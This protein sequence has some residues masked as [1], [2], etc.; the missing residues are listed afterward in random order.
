MAQGKTVPEVVRKLGVTEQ[1]YY[2]WKRE[3]GGLRTD[4]AK[5]L[6]DLEKENA[7]LKRFGIWIGLDFEAG[8]F[9]KREVRR[10]RRGV[11]AFGQDH[12]PVRIHEIRHVSADD[13]L[14]AMPPPRRLAVQPV[15][16]QDLD[17]ATPVRAVGGDHNTQGAPACCRGPA[18]DFG[19]SGGDDTGNFRTDE[20]NSGMEQSRTRSNV[21]ATGFEPA[22]STS[23]T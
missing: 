5:R 7:R 13:A 14:P 8:K 12:L 10:L 22:T 2:R 18:V 20:P 9:G 4:Q 19:A 1:T 6:E 17:A 21:G 15:R 23:R 3:Y 16:R 11:I